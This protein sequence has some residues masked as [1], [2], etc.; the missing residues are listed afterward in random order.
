MP[1]FRP[2]VFFLANGMS[3]KRSIRRTIMNKELL[4]DASA[5]AIRYLEGLGERPVAPPAAAVEQLRAFDEP[6]PDRETDPA[7]TL[8]LLDEIGS[9]GTMGMAGS[10]FFGLVIGGALPVTVAANSLA[11]AWDQNTGL[12]RPTPTTSFLEQVSLRWLLDVLRLPP[13]CTGAFV[14]GATVANFCALAAA[15]HSVLK[16]AG[17]NAVADGRVGA[18]PITVI[19][20]AEAH[21]SVTKS[22]GLL[23]LGRSRV[24][25]VPVDNQGRMLADKLPAISGPT[26]ICVQ[27]GNVNTGSFDPLAEIC[28]VAHAAGAWVHVDGAFGLWAAATPSRVHLTEGIANA[29][30]WAT[31]AH[32][33]LNVPYDCGLAITRHA[34]DHRRAFGAHAAYLIESGGPADPMELVPEFSRRSRGVPV[35]AALRSLGRTGVADLVERCCRHARQ[36]ADAFGSAPGVEILNDVVLNQVLVRFD[37][38]DVTTAAVVE[39]VLAE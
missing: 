19:V 3:A 28:R 15:R 35:Y 8:R 29:D 13:E 26:I 38:D 2:F 16:Q 20:S 5:R 9:P 14:T 4:T 24:V 10:P 31:D 7:E 33:W 21:P 32:K 34:A 39:E 37:D 11:T 36:F 18:P 1:D 12:Y 27:A 25:K 30:S 23:G 17:W 6:F 22:L